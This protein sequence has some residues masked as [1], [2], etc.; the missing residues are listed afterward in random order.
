MKNSYPFVRKSYTMQRMGQATERAINA[1]TAPE[2]ERAARW[3][4]AWGLL[5]GIMT[6]KVNVK[7]SDINMTE[8]SGTMNAS[9]HKNGQINIFAAPSGIACSTAMPLPTHLVGRID[10]RSMAAPETVAASSSHPFPDDP[11]R[12]EAR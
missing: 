4:A 1:A 2:K 10:H 12:Q 8:P 3:A 11:S 5:C 9:K 6:S 7:R